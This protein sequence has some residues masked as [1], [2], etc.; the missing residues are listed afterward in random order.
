MPMPLG[1]PE[2][3]P[4]ALTTVPSVGQCQ[5]GAGEACAGGDALGTGLRRTEA[6]GGGARDAAAGGAARPVTVDAER[7]AVEPD[8]EPAA[9]PRIEPAA[10]LGVERAALL[11]VARATVG[12]PILAADCP[13]A[14]PEDDAADED[15]FERD[16]AGVSR[17]GCPTRIMSGSASRFQRARSR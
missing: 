14:G 12:G 9:E 13:A 4:K 1:I 15:E 8:E 3:D 16:E 17:I 2:L 7:P 6:G 5:R 10:E 11:G